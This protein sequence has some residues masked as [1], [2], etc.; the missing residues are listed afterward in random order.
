M[1]ARASRCRSPPTPGTRA[2]RS[3]TASSTSAGVAAGHAADGLLGG[4]V[5]D[6]DLLVRGGRAPLAADQHRCL[7]GSQ[8]VR[9]TALRCQIAVAVAPGTRLRRRA[10]SSSRARARQLLLL[11]RAGR[12]RASIRGADLARRSDDAPRRRRPS[13]RAPTPRALQHDR[14]HPDQRA[15]LDHAALEHARRGRRSRRSPTIVGRSSAQWIDRVVL[16]RRCRRRSSMR[17]LVAAQ[18]GAEPDVRAVAD[19]HVADQHRGRREP[20]VLADRGCGRPSS[21][22]EQ[23]SVA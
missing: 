12:R 23:S 3:A 15:V 11:D 14:A 13:R 21:S 10:R 6:L 7:H 18:H 20:D 4:R 17:E 9:C 22:I 5:D 19:A 8:S 2:W 1:R 16:D